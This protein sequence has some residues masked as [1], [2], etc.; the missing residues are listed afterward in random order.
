MSVCPVFTTDDDPDLEDDTLYFAPPDAQRPK[1]P[2]FPPGL[3]R[4]AAPCGVVWAGT[5]GTEWETVKTRSNTEGPP[6]LPWTAAPCGVVRANPGTEKKMQWHKHVDCDA[7]GVSAP[8]VVPCDMAGIGDK[9]A[10]AITELLKR[11]QKSVPAA[12]PCG[13]AGIKEEKTAERPILATAPCG[14]VRV[15]RGTIDESP[16]ADVGGGP[17]R[18]DRRRDVSQ[19]GEISLGCGPLRRGRG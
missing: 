17:L 15:D 19:G 12:A 7:V 8:A 6:G 18:R 2:E 4:T 11:T 9:E 5:E 3:S 16:R 10:K 1:E 14:A 13:V